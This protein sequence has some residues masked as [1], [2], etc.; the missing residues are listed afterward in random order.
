MGLPVRK[1]KVSIPPTCPLSESMAL[2]K[3]GTEEVMWVA[4]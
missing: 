3:N 1:N 2:P 4:Q